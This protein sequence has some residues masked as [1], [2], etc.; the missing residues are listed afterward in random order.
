MLIVWTLYGSLSATPLIPLP[1][2]SNRLEMHRFPLSAVRALF[3][4]T[5]ERL[6]QK[7]EKEKK[8]P[9]QGTTKKCVDG[10]GYGSEISFGWSQSE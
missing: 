1:F 2:T 9:F 5:E 10:V 7:T 3:W 8:Q 6:G 4:T